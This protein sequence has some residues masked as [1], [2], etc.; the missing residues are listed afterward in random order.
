L[1]FWPRKYYILKLGNIQMAHFAQLNSDNVVINVLV[2]NDDYLKDENGNEVEELGA[3]HMN[4]VH[5]GTWKQTSYNANIRVHYAGI[6][7]S[8]DERLDAFVPPKP[9]GNWILNEETIEWE[10]HVNT[11]I[12]NSEPESN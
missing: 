1:E 11:S 10:P 12:L 4:R 3:A 2:V 9:Q 8:Y 7:Y 6:G 5:G